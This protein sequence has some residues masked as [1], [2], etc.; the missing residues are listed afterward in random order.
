MD[1]NKKQQKN[2]IKVARNRRNK[3]AKK[4]QNSRNVAKIAKKQLRKIAKVAEKAKIA[5]KQPKNGGKKLA[6]KQPKKQPKLK[7]SEQIAEKQPE[8]VVSSIFGQIS[9]SG[10]VQVGN[11]DWRYSQQLQR[12]RCAAVVQATS[13]NNVR[14][15]F[16]F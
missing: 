16:Y 10:L 14:V 6:K 13:N 5:K 7:I 11:G 2:G 3:M 8:I 4:Q 12:A 15:H 9:Y 1:L